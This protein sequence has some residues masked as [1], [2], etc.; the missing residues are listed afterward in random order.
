MNLEQEA[1]AINAVSR[2]IERV[3]RVGRGAE[4]T[5][6]NG[7][8]LKIKSVPPFLYQAV[9]NEFKPP[10]PPKVMIEEKGREEENPNDPEYL[11]LLLELDEQQSLAI[12]NLFLAYGTE[13]LSVPEGYYRPEEDGWIAKVEFAQN[14]TG[15]NIHIDRDDEIQRYLNWLR[16]YALETGGDIALATRLP[17]EL[18]GIREGE[19]EEV[20]E[21]FRS[22]P[23][24][25][26][27]PQDSAEQG[28][29]NGHTANR[30]TRRTR[31]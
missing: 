11:R 28:N 30:A 22:L 29:S 6:S 3:R 12:N 27:D 1:E 26:T 31:S 21:S 7:I 18:G 13:I 10:N 19:V 2:A 5:L 8:V 16:Y 4:F 17:M 15:K 25:R 20:M 14:I 24:R 9:Q 23:E